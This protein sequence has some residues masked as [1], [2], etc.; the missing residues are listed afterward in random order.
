MLFNKTFPLIPNVFPTFPQEHSK[1]AQ[2]FP[3]I[4]ARPPPKYSKIAFTT[5]RSRPPEILP[6]SYN[7]SQ[8]PAKVPQDPLRPPNILPRPRVSAS[9]EEVGKIQTEGLGGRFLQKMLLNYYITIL[10]HQHIPTP[11][12]LHAP[13]VISFLAGVWH[14]HLCSTS[15]P[16][17]SVRDFTK[18]LKDFPTTLPSSPKFFSRHN[19]KSQNSQNYTRP[20]KGRPQD[21]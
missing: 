6:N 16:F 5:D 17:R 20:L 10:L 3:K 9:V 12:H 13:Q 11:S 1:I 19:H 4:I 18:L 7:T 2:K 21:F 8:S 14:A 15:H